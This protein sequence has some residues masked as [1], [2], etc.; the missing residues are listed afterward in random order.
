MVNHRIYFI[1]I[2]VSAVLIFGKKKSLEIAISM[3]AKCPGNFCK[4][5]LLQ[6]QDKSSVFSIFTI[7][8]IQK[9]LKLFG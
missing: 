8:M 7:N 1:Q 4:R 6:I 9:S 3:L 2:G 5:Q